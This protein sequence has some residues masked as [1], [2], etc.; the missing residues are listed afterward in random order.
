[1]KTLV[2]IASS[3]GGWGQHL[4]LSILFLVVA[5]MVMACGGGGKN[6]QEE[7]KQIAEEK[8]IEITASDLLSQY[9]DN[10]VKANETYKGKVV[11][12]SGI[13]KRITERAVELKGSG[14][15]E[16]LTVDC[17]FEDNDKKAM[18]SLTGGQDVT[19]KGI[20]NGKGPFAVEIKRCTLIK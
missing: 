6:K 19:I 8:A 18:S 16:L 20:C 3:S 1:M 11:Q 7:A 12:V 5:I 4:L 13:V 17:R 10:E 15:F 2:K 14:R 9:K